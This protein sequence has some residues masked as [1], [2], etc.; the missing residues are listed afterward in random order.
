MSERP[1]TVVSLNVRGLGKDS[2]K[3]K[4]SRPG[5]PLS[6]THLMYYSFKNTIWTKR[7]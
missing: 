6:K 7:G 5:C 2:A 1:F 3:Q 4:I